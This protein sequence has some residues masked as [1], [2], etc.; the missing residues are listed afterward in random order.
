[1]HINNDTNDEHLY[2]W[3][4]KNINNYELLDILNNIFNYKDSL[5][6]DEIN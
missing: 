1:M 4:K 2:L 3:Y 5:K 6:V